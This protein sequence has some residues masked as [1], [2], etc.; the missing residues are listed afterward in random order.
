MVTKR[1]RQEPALS[2]IQDSEAAEAAVRSLI[3]RFGLT[4]FQDNS[5]GLE[6]GTGVSFSKV[7]YEAVAPLVG[8][9]A[10]ENLTDAKTFEIHRS[11]IPTDLFKSIVMDMD[12]M[13]IQYGPLPEHKTEEARSRF[14]SPI[15]NHIVKQFS[16]VLRNEPE[17]IIAG[18]IGSRGRVEYFFKAF[19]ATAILC[20]EM[21][22]K[23]ENDT[24][25]LDAIAQVIAECDGCDL[26]NKKYGFSLPIHGILC[27]GSSF[28]FFRFERADNPL[29]LRGCVAGDPEH[30]K[31]GLLLLDFKKTETPLPF[32]LDLRRACETVFDIM[33]CAY[34]SGLQAYHDRS[35]GRGEKEGSKRL[36]F[37][38][39]DEAIKSAQEALTT[40]REAEV[41]RHNGDI[42]SADRRVQEALCALQK[43]SG[44]VPTRYKTDLIMTGWDDDQVSKR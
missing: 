5:S 19:G 2:E 3:E 24:E 20:I 29:F 6:G 30:L 23:I 43:S 12:V 7:T 21:K 1:K 32:I 16:F 22:L 37:D 31:R 42:D 25:R 4:Q 11:R 9:D 33:L 36:S 44:A 26:N 27:N 10:Y 35:K 14:F 34:I 40:F 39:W 8:L 17:T 41:H 13:L 15:F 28:E 38:K 18:R